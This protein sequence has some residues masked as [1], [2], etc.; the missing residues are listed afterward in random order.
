MN[1]K[2]LIFA[3]ITLGSFAVLL[4]FF[5]GGLGKNPQLLPSVVTGKALPVIDLPA[6]NGP[7]RIH[8]QDLPQKKP[9]LLNVWGSWC[10]A[11]VAE[12]PYLLQLQKTI[13]IVGLNWPADNAGESEDGANFLTRHGNPYTTIMTDPDG[14]LITA[15]GV[16]GA[17]ETFLIDAQGRIV[18]RYAGPLSAEIW[19]QQFLPLLEKTP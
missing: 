3:I 19:Q 1:K 10:P 9:Y 12:H 4:G 18:F 2:S 8:N 16:Y 14:T 13:P 6:F 5:I 7:G 11:C 17:P 15:L